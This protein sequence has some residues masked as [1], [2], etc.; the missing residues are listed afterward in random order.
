MPSAPPK[1][2]RQYV[3]AILAAL[4]L[5]A[6]QVLFVD[7]NLPNVQAAAA[8]GIHGEH[9]PSNSGGSCLSKLLDKHGVLAA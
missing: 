5:P 1:P 6:E 8:V 9:F 2:E 3:S 7:D 4:D